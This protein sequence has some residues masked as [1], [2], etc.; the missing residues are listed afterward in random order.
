MVSWSFV[1][2]SLNS[3]PNELRFWGQERWHSTTVIKPPYHM[4]L[5]THTYTYFLIHVYVCKRKVNFVSLCTSI[6][7]VTFKKL[8]FKI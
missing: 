6:I 5:N 4:L 8:N 2:L 3:S 7:L 1:A